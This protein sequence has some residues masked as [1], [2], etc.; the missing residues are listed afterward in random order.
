MPTYKPPYDSPIET[1]FA[2]HFITKYAADDLEFIPQCEVNTIC[3]RF[4]LD[5]VLRLQNGCQVG[6]EC[7][8]QA[9]HD[10]WRDEWRDAI[11]L[12]EKHVDA[13]YRLRGYDITYHLD[14]ILYIMSQLESNLFSFRGK[15]KLERLA[16]DEARRSV[17]DIEEQYLRVDYENS[18][19]LNYLFMQVRRGSTPKNQPRYWQ[20]LYKYAVKRGGGKLDEIIKH[21][22]KD[23]RQ[24][25]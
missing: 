4:I 15:L 17:Y 2:Y 24:V 22:E 9:F 10:T 6:I 23:R 19:Y 20:K 7:D 13:I 21:Y 18:H 16:T 11:I 3:G 1:E 14:D 25:N 12:G 8:G 5:F